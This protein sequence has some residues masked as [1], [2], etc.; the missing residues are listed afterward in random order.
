MGAW[1]AFPHREREVKGFGRSLE[2]PTYQAGWEKLRHLCLVFRQGPTLWGWR[3]WRGGVQKQV[4]NWEILEL[5][6]VKR[7]GMCRIGGLG[8]CVLEAW[9][10]KGTGEGEGRQ[11]RLCLW[12][13]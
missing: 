10:R 2:D 11:E 1:A 7:S 5:M 9:C 12:E 6:L 4:E 8:G 13:N 3:S